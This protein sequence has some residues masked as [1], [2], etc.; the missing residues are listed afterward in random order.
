ME[1][2]IACTGFNIPNIAFQKNQ[3]VWKCSLK[4]YNL[5]ISG[6][7][8]QKNQ[9]VW[10]CVKHGSDHLIYLTISEKLVSMEVPC[11]NFYFF[12]LIPFQKNQ[13]VWKLIKSA[14]ILSGL[15]TISEK[16]V[17]MEVYTLIIHVRLCEDLISEKLVSMEVQKISVR[18]L[19]FPSL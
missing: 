4:S 9:L 12:H 10:K 5:K 17:S 6:S 1:V 16:L 11:L 19:C 8:F 13:L 3:L 18:C 7:Q 15:Y 2:T 14:F